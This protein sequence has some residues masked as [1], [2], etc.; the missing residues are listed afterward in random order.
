MVLFDV[1]WLV[2]GRYFLLYIRYLCCYT[3]KLDSFGYIKLY[4]MTSI[5]YSGCLSLTL[6]FDV[7]MKVHFNCLNQF[8]NKNKIMKR[9]KQSKNKYLFY[10]ILI[11]RFY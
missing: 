6:N 4:R 10:D 9:M 5:F 1:L 8:A 11:T 2:I 3:K 7:K